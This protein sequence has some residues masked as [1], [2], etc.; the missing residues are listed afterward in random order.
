MRKS[1]EEVLGEPGHANQVS[2][3][4]SEDRLL[5]DSTINATRPVDEGERLG[6]LRGK[7][8]PREAS[9]SAGALGTRAWE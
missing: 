2:N 4:R 6:M 3:R 5:E 7:C 8:L 1:V 9:H